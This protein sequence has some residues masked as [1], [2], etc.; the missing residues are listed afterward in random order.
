MFELFD[1]VNES[2]N[3]KQIQKRKNEIK[4]RQKEKERLQ[5]IAD[6]RLIGLSLGV[7]LF[8]YIAMAATNYIFKFTW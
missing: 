2:A 1:S 7:A 8:L 3:Q 4:K 5:D 6:Y